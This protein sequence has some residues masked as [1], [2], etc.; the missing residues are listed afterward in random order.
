[1]KDSKPSYAV[2]SAVSLI[3]ITAGTVSAALLIMFVGLFLT[4]MSI[5]S[6][7][8]TTASASHSPE[9]LRMVSSNHFMAHGSQRT[10]AYQKKGHVMDALLREENMHSEISSGHPN[11]APYQPHVYAITTI[12]KFPVHGVRLVQI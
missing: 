3:A 10:Q 11:K 9:A 6:T 2:T 7:S 5:G 8:Q 1:M 4:M 12:V